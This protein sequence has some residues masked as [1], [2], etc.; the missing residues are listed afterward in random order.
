M[1]SLITEIKRDYFSLH[2]FLISQFCSKRSHFPWRS[3]VLPS[4]KFESMINSYSP[5][6][7]SNVV[8][9]NGVAITDSTF[10]LYSTSKLSFDLPWNPFYEI[11]FSI[12][13]SPINQVSNGFCV[14]LLHLAIVLPSVIRE[15]IT[16]SYDRLDMS[17]CQVSGSAIGIHIDS[18]SLS[19]LTKESQSS[20]FRRYKVA[21]N[22]NVFD[23]STHSLTFHFNLLYQYLS[24][25]ID[26]E[27]VFMSEDFVRQTSSI[28]TFEIVPVSVF[29]L[30]CYLIYS[31]P[32]RSAI[33]LS[34]PKLLLLMI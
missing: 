14:K 6:T 25:F 27:C 29:S 19:I 15:G 33:F 5:I 3:S 1:N 2:I 9:E 4:L 30:F 24:V 18:N 10:E 13:S 11:T 8:L 20:L 21:L 23:D 22:T 17:P 31:T 34:I 28:K 32:S 12:Q 7:S 26:S 16:V